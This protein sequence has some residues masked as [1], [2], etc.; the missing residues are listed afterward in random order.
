VDESGISQLVGQHLEYLTLGRPIGRGVYGWAFRATDN[1]NN[2]ELAVKFYA[3]NWVVKHTDLFNRLIDQ[4]NQ[5]VGLQ[6]PNLIESKDLIL[7]KGAEDAPIALLVMDLATRG[8][9][10]NLVADDRHADLMS[11]THAIKQAAAGLAYLHSEDVV[12]GDLKPTNLLVDSEGHI[13]VGDAGLSCLVDEMG[14]TTEPLLTRPLPYYYSPEQCKGEDPTAASD[15]YSLGACFYH[16]LIGETPYEG[17][18]PFQLF[19]GHTE[20]PIPDPTMKMPT[21]PVITTQIINKAMAKDPE[22]RYGSVEMMIEDLAFVLQGRNTLPPIGEP[23]DLIEQHHE[24]GRKQAAKSVERPIPVQPKKSGLP[25]IPIIGVAVVIVLLAGWFGFKSS[26]S[27]TPTP[28]RR[29]VAIVSPSPSGG[30][31]GTLPRITPPSL[32]TPS[33]EPTPETAKRLEIPAGLPTLRAPV[34]MSVEPYEDPS[35]AFDAADGNLFKFKKDR[36]WTKITASSPEWTLIGT[37]KRPLNRDAHELELNINK[38]LDQN[39]P[40]LVMTFSFGYPNVSE[41]PIRFP[42]DWDRE[43]IQRRIKLAA[44]EPQR[45]TVKLSAAR[46][47]EKRLAVLQFDLDPTGGVPKVRA[48]VIPGFLSATPGAIK[49]VEPPTEWTASSV[50][51]MVILT[52]EELFIS[53]EGKLMAWVDLRAD[54]DTRLGLS[55]PRLTFKQDFETFSDGFL[56][57]GILGVSRKPAT[58]ARLI[59]GIR[60]SDLPESEWGPISSQTDIVGRTGR[61]SIRA[62]GD[63]VQVTAKSR[64]DQD[65]HCTLR[66]RN[67]TLRPDRIFYTRIGIQPQDASARGAWSYQIGFSP[68][69]EPAD[70]VGIGNGGRVVVEPGQAPADGESLIEWEIYRDHHKLDSIVNGQSTRI[71]LGEDV[72]FDDM[73]LNVR[74]TQQSKGS[75]V[76]SQTAFIIGE[77][78]EDVGKKP[79]SVQEAQDRSQLTH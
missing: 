34:L 37:P 60:P 2:Q 41:A 66:F 6:H 9:L 52:K 8:H 62:I 40:S 16:L 5:L 28:T 10:G 44:V 57:V 64:G 39:N 77:I 48:Q 42:K 55:Q 75:D 74:V 24:P 25:L 58:A 56:E 26:F 69:G 54:K 15:I 79:K 29:S 17:K 71:N 4:C 31:I 67:L 1:R 22:D 30:N 12:H 13:R 65:E 78:Q 36:L 72:S 33:L 3:G 70:F 38:R 68:S 23:D 50:R 11:A 43:F 49:V 61:A 32:P 20:D 53:V 27:E 7:T 63:A 45:Y 47:Q 51:T 21:L 14:L 73:A 59:E 18:S 19:R 46:T 35:T 76:E